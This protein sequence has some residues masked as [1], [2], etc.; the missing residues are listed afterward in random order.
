MTKITVTAEVRPSEN[1]AKVLIAISNFFDFENLKSE[2]KEYSKL[3]IAES[4][5][6]RSLEKLHKALREERILDVA[7]K[8]LRKGM[9]SDSITFMLHKQSAA[10]GVVSFVDDEKESPLGPIVFYIEYKKPEE[11][12]DW[13]APRTSKGIPLWDN[14]IP[15]D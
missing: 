8:Y 15:E 4:K 3:I 13:L 11:V 5:T 14:P 2:K 10:V 9:S 7:R 6:L 1:E 12:I